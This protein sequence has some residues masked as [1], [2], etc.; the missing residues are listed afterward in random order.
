MAAMDVEALNAEILAETLK[1]AEE[2]QARFAG[3]AEGELHAWLRIALRREAMVSDFYGRA[4]RE[5][6]L[7]EPRVPVGDVA[8]KAFTLIWQQ[9]E[10]HTRF[11]EV[12][13][14]DGMFKER[15]RTREWPRLRG[16]IESKTLSG[17]TSRPGLRSAL[18]KL[19]VRLGARVAQ[20]M[21]P[22]FVLK[23][24]KLE[25]REFFL[26]CSVLETTARQSYA[27]ME[28]LTDNL[29][30]RSLEAESLSRELRLKLLEET[31]HEQAF[32]MM[33]DWIVGGKFAPALDAKTCARKLRRLLP[34]GAKAVGD[35]ESRFVL[36]DGGLSKLFEEYGMPVVIE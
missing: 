1:L 17:I 30:A 28:K 25:V 3:D 27:R 4:N 21:V 10:V 19:A 26:L 13:L 32:K 16:T 31:F 7:P 5:Y 33:A 35:P 18:A 34:R 9:E 2:Y 24:D 14:K 23:L 36:T 15:A 11:I 12:T 29:P 20:G 6:R 8:W 22:A